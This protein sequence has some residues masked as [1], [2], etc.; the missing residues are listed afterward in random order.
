MYESLLDELK[1]NSSLRVLREVVSA[2]ARAYLD[3]VEYLNFSG[4]DYLG[5][6]GETELRREFFAEISADAPALSAA[7]SRLLTG[8][9]PEYAGL[10]REILDFHHVSPRE[11]R[12]LV[13]NSGYHANVG[14]LPALAG[15]GDAIFSDKLNHASIIDG[16]QLGNAEYLRY[17]HLDYASL[18]RRLA[19]AERSGKYRKKF[20]I[21]ESVFS[22]DGDAADLRRIVE[23]KRRYDAILLVD[24][25]HSVGVFGPGGAGWAAN[26]G[27][28]EEIDVL[29][30]TFGKAFGSV[31]A[32][33]ICR[34]DAA[35]YLV[36]K[37]RPL[38]FSTGLPPLNLRWSKKVM[39][40]VAG[41]DDRREHL[42]ENADFLRR[43]L[44]AMGWTTGGETQIVPVIVGGE[45]ETAALADFLMQKRMLIFPIRPPTVPAGKSRLRLSLNAA[46]SRADAEKLLEA[47]SRWK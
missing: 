19:E 26:Q 21:T 23:L 24:E 35:E 15:K 3:G 17:P 5:V 4:N 18:E 45:A 33:A 25:A 43:E 36:N 44:A 6:G 41:W 2:G 28:A 8:N 31:G 39:R 13:F 11:R 9:S 29:I 46:H 37:M 22:M 12:A 16:L 42:R 47:F 1:K 14:I 10:E 34:P 38:I 7:S 40:T 30:G 20:I 32:Y 27:V